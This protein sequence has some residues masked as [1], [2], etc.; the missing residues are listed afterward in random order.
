MNSK[1]KQAF[2]LVEVLVA[3]AIT[4]ILAALLLP[5][6]SAAKAKADRATCV[7][8]FKQ[9]ALGL[10]SYAD[11]HGDQL[12]GPVWQGF[13]ENYD[14]QD[15][16]RLSYYIASYLGQPA[17]CPNPQ[18][19]RLARCPAAARHWNAAA[20]DIPLMDLDR[21]LSYI[22][23]IAVTNANSGVVTRPFGYPYSHIPFSSENEA[24][25][26]LR[27]IGSPGLSWAMTDADQLNASPTG[28]Y[29]DFLP[30]TPAH[31]NVRNQLFFDWHVTAVLR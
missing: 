12:P 11:D 25:K 5:A 24:P 3:I 20:S 21:P 8:N 1:S 16:V 17:P 4:A 15:T 13:Y 9:L 26:R 27:E 14:N 30:K 23:S 7:N 19:N 18:L 6:L 2:T 10:Q 29:Y 22:V 28:S 31:G